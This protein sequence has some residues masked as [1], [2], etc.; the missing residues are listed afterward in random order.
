[1]SP[2]KTHSTA[3]SQKAVIAIAR[4]VESVIALEVSASSVLNPLS[5]DQGDFGDRRREIDEP[6]E[7]QDQRRHDEE[8]A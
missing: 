3:R 5:R 2:I 8:H 6:R 7:Q 4:I 1:M